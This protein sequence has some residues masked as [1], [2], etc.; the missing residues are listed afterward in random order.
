MGMFTTFFHPT[1]NENLQIKTGY[2]QCAMYRLGDDVDFRV[3]EDAG[4]AHLND[5]AYFAESYDNPDQVGYFVIIKGQKYIAVENAIKGRPEVCRIA[6]GAVGQAAYWC[7]KYG[8]VP[9]PLDTW[10]DA[11]WARKAKEAEE[12][13]RRLLTWDVENLELEL[14]GKNPIDPTTRF[15]QAKMKEEGIFRR[16]MSP[17]PAAGDIAGDGPVKVLD[18]EGS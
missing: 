1:T 15:T 18:Q 8:I 14:S 4:R 9:L 2:D 12:S 5:G 17:V 13:R 3:R 16:I 11:A 6:Y 10:S 7:V